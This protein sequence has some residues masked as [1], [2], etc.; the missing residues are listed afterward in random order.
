LSGRLSDA[1]R[2]FHSLGNYRLQFHAFLAKLKFVARDSANIQ[3]VI[4]QSHH[5][6]ELP[7][8]RIAGRAQ[9]GGIAMDVLN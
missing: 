7:L 8:H 9:D 4:D 6:G 3:Q 2:R 1:P 5:V